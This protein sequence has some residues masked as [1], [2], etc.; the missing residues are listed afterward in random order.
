MKQS[1]RRRAFCREQIKCKTRKNARTRALAAND[2]AA[3]IIR[4]K[5]HGLSSG[6][7]ALSPCR[8][9]YRELAGAQHR[10]ATVNLC[11]RWRRF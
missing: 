8:R 10:C 3:S 11:E 5:E 7:N 2:R 4:W 9:D 6:E 1:Y